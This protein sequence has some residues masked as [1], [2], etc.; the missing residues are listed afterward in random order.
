[1][2]NL[3]LNQRLV[4]GFGVLVAGAGI[5]GVTAEVSLQTLGAHVNAITT[6]VV[7][8][9]RGIGEIE[10][11]AQNN[12][13]VLGEILR[14]DDKAERAPLIA[15]V[16]DNTDKLTAAI[17]QYEATILTDE[18]RR[19]TRE[20]VE[21]R[22]A[23]LR[24]RDASI[25]LR[26][27]DKSAEARA[28]L[29]D[30]ARPAFDKFLATLVALS[31]WNGAHGAKIGAEVASSVDGARQTIWIVLGLTLLAGIAVAVAIGRSVSRPMRL[32]L[33]HVNHVGRG[34]LDSRC[35]YEALDEMG[36]LAGELNKMTEDLKVARETDRQRAEGEQE[37]RQALQQKVDAILAT[38]Q[39]VAQ[40]DLTQRVS[41]VGSDAIGQLGEGFGRLIGD[42]NQNMGSISR[43]AHALSASSDELTSSS[44]MMAA[45]SE[46]TSAQAASV[47]AAAEQVS[48]NVHTVAAG[49]EEMIASIKEIARNAHEAT[50]IATSAV[51][52][53]E[54][55]SGTISKL[56]DS[57]VE[58]GKVVKVI[59]SIAEQTNLLALNATIEAARAGEAG[60]GFAVVANEVKELAK[61]TA[62]ATEDIS[63]KID[64]I[65][66]DTSEAVKAIKEIRVIIAQVNDIS[67]TIAGAVE[68]QA[69]T[70]NDIGRNVS[71][72]AVG[73]SEI[74]RNI[75]GVAESARNTASGATQTQAASG[76]LSQMAGELQEMVSR[77]R[78]D[79]VDGRAAHAAA[80]ATPPSRATRARAPVPAPNGPAHANGAPSSWEE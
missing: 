21:A 3:K 73:V 51:R 66:G 75:T 55:T 1:M 10:S 11:R 32:L 70:A 68:E 26:E 72:A 61:E 15:K 65:Q 23:W 54:V 59:T 79:R 50:R 74:A 6:D 27:Q 7:P 14:I 49:A 31:S 4:L 45:N 67:N 12:F 57:S 62:K 13:G 41:V 63:Q 30:R 17:H 20:M 29:N 5:I 76:A 36:Q 35:A 48:K 58:I 18:D 80:G 9:L 46:E 16:R 43:N 34:E 24:S 8:G 47:S 56:G 2:K 53:A 39:T 22:E 64:A 78:I 44:Q 38:V 71:Q 42:L 60:K 25:A 33:E 28:E 37:E 69:S 52:V 19:L 77:F 40:G